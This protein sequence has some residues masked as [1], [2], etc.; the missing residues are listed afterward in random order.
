MKAWVLEKQATVEE[1]PLLRREVPIPQVEEAEIRIKVHAS[2]L[3]RTDIHVAEGDLP[4]IKSPL[5]LGH[6]IAGVVDEVGKAVTKFK[7]GDRAGIAWLNS[8]C[9]HCQFCQ[10]GRENLCP[11]GNIYRLDRRWWIR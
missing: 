11:E 5:I 3:C 2:G 1:K 9:G 4:L 10:S 8:T 7:V 6:Q